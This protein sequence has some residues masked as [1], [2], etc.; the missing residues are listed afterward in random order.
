MISTTYISNT[1]STS[2]K[3]LKVSCDNSKSQKEFEKTYTFSEATSRT[4]NP[5]VSVGPLALRAEIRTT[6]GGEASYNRIQ[7]YSYTVKLPPGKKG[8]VYVS[9]KTEIIKFKHVIQLQE[10]ELGEPDSKYKNVGKMRTE[11]SSLTTKSPV[12]I[13]EI[14]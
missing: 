10:K 5:S 4:M 2:K 6:L 9:E 11:F 14:N 13:L 7:S 1:T 12:F 8:R 3:D